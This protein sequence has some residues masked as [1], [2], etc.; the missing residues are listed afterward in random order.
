MPQSTPD[1]DLVTPSRG[2]SGAALS[3]SG[4]VSTTNY[5]VIPPTCINL[6]GERFGRLVCLGAISKRR[7]GY[8]Y[9]CRCDCGGMAAVQSGNLKSGHTQSCGC[10][11]RE[12]TSEA[13]GRHRRSKTR[14]YGVWM[15]MRQRC[16]LPTSPNYAFYGGRG[17]KVCERW[18]GNF[19]AFL[20]DMGEQPHGL[21]LD[22]INPNGDYEPS[23]C[24]W[25]SK[26]DQARNT[27]RNVY[28][29]HDGVTMI[30]SDWDRAIGSKDRIGKRLR[31]GQ[32]IDDLLNEAIKRMQQ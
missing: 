8:V 15:Q 16:L 23:N 21:S 18:A 27:R 22:R 14:L 13:N 24:R 25:V 4:A 2:D 7:N 19:E 31:R 30:L 11:M 9:S 29:T 5:I 3:A 1:T 10:M 26:R 17:I 28:L 32:P 6:V 12:R 20:V